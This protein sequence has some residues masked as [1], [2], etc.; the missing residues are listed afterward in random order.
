MKKKRKVYKVVRVTKTGRYSCCAQGKYSKKYKKGTTMKVGGVGAMCFKTIEQ[1][2]NLKWLLEG[3]S[4][5]RDI[6]FSIIELEPIGWP[7]RPKR[8]TSLYPAEELD[9]FYKGSLRYYDISST[10]PHEGT[11]CYKKV[12]VLT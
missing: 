12:K 8:W 7:S 10:P 1:A 4:Q 2:K 3:K 11:V 6:T 9:D 5:F